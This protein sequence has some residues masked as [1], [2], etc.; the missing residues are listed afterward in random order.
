MAWLILLSGILN[1]FLGLIVWLRDLKNRLN[2]GFGIFSLSTVVLILFDFFFRFNPT[3][4]VLKSSYAFAALVPI[5][6]LIWIL[7]MCHIDASRFSSLR[8]IMIFLPG[9]VF[10][11]LPYIDN[12]I[13]VQVH[14][15]TLLGYIGKLG[16]LFALYAL[17]FFVYILAF[18]IL[19]YR[20]QRNTTDR[21]YK[22]QIRFVL[23][24]VVLYGL[25]AIT[26]SLILPKFFGIFDFT[27][28]D[29]PSLI[30]FVGFTAYAILKLH[31]FNIK[32]IATELLVFALSSFSL[33]RTIVSDQL[34][35]QIINGG[36]FLCILIVGVFLI[37][38]VIN[39]VAQREK[40]EKL[41]KELEKAN[42]RLK[43][44]DALKTEFISFATHQLRAPITAIKGYTSEILE[45]DFGSVPDN[46]KSPAEVIMES[47]SSLAV[48]VDD[49][50][51]V[52]RIEQ[53]KMK[54]EFSDFNLGDLVNEVANEQRLSVEKKG[55]KLEVK[56]DGGPP[57][58]EAG[59]QIHADRGK[60]KQVI[61]NLLDNAVKYT[62]AGQIIIAL[63]KQDGKA[64]LSVKDTGAG[65]KPE[66][67]PHL[68]Q[69]F[70]R[71]SD[72]S[73]Y[74]LFGTG[75]GL[76]LASELLKAHHGKI[77]AE[78]EGDGKGSAF[79]VELHVV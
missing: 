33:I 26:S 22:I 51:N 57:G 45:G 24:G 68:F 79:F 67:M 50:L 20:V 72:A 10:F 63:T 48:L 41:A 17:Y 59:A 69:K 64:R 19:L 58:G 65:I 36:I 21:I 23:T 73:K 52:S 6:A 9:L 38:S 29:A 54:Y 39:E 61:M 15:L 55:L 47:S 40:I 5:T 12:S 44:L 27:L 66:T 2:L 71:A 56:V 35:D 70:S 11:V 14:S 37:R 30:F 60:I 49:Y 32:V 18:I 78:S 46:L 13:V 43:E 25:T 74:N 3:V 28:L 76:Y 42:E 62:P 4:F 8:K 1:L 77:W 53:G 34:N 7:E 16:P 31:L 75:L